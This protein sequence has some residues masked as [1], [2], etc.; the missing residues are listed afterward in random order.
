M[1]DDAKRL[2]VHELSLLIELKNPS[3]IPAHDYMGDTVWKDALPITAIICRFL[4][5]LALV[6]VRNPGAD[7]VT[8]VSLDVSGLLPAT[9]RPG[10]E[11]KSSPEKQAATIRI[12]QNGDVA[13]E[14]VT[15]VEDIIRWI[16]VFGRGTSLNISFILSHIYYVYLFINT[17]DH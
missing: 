5:M 6:C 15:F 8:A 7:Q 13:E 4:D 14:T 12:A 2:R 11:I 1:D 10:M 16:T 17:N 9:L 3:L